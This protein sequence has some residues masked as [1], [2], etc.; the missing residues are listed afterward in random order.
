MAVSGE[1]G[2]VNASSQNWGVL[3]HRRPAPPPPLPSPLFHPTLGRSS[4][5]GVSPDLDTVDEPSMTSWISC[6]G[7]GRGFTSTNLGGRGS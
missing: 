6:L 1:R 2:G 3:A 4:A 7:V 5:P